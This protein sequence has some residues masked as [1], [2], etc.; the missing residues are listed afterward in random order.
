MPRRRGAQRRRSARGLGRVL[1]AEAID[2]AA[3][4]LVYWIV[5]LVE[6]QIEVFTRPSGP[7]E[8]PDYGTRQIFHAR[9]DLAVVLDGSE[10]GRIA[11]HELLP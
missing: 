2:A 3:G 6:R 1:L 7:G 8:R 11:V 9:L 4:I 10:M 5:N